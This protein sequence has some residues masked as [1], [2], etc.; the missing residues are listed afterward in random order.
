MINNGHWSLNVRVFWT[1]STTLRTLA[2]ARVPEQADRTFSFLPKLVL[3]LGQNFLRT[4][5][6][7]PHQKH[8]GRKCVSRASGLLES[9]TLS[10]DWDLH[11]SA[12]SMDS[13]S[14]SQTILWLSAAAAH[15]ML[16]R[17]EFELL[18]RNLVSWNQLGSKT[19]KALLEPRIKQTFVEMRSGIQYDP[20][21]S[22]SKNIKQ[23][24][25]CSAA[26]L[27]RRHGFR[28]QNFGQWT[29]QRLQRKH[30]NIGSIPKKCFVCQAVQINKIQHEHVNMLCPLPPLLAL[31]AY[32]PPF[33]L[34]LW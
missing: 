12:S 28:S 23:V 20:V 18:L 19:L 25:I 31:Y 9:K 2:S 15:D 26:M 4:R 32:M 30:V 13:L 1:S 5:R 29:S 11:A 7:G 6:M 16:R 34:Q 24:K 21:Q 33:V 17:G 8:S 3:P 27:P 22:E 14:C 10:T